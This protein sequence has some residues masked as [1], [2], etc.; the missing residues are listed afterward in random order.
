MRTA[1]GDDDVYITH[2]EG[3][4][5]V[6]SSFHS[7]G[8]W[9]YGVTPDGLTLDPEAPQYLGVV[10]DH[11]ELAAGWLHAMR[12]TVASSELREGSCE[13]A[14]QR[15]LVEVPAGLEFDA[16]SI[17]LFLR[18]PEAEL[19][20]VDR[21][22]VIAELARAGGGAAV[23]LARPMNLDAPVPEALASQIAEMRDGMREHGWDG[24]VPTRG[25]IFGGDEDGFL[26][27]VEVAIDPD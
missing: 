23:L 19:I 1:A 8:E 25:V 11:A 4:R 10:T 9:H 27:Q 13:V 7:S 3:G 26:R 14:R 22:L 5:W 20:R 15:D 6:H 17:D 24:S 12:I 16:L 21:A 18:D 2:R